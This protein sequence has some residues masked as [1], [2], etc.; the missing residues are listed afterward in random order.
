MPTSSTPL[1]TQHLTP[2]PGGAA[3]QPTLLVVDDTPASLGVVCEALRGTGAKILIADT[4]RAARAILSRIIPELILLDVVM[5][6]EDGFSF[7]E[8]LKTDPRWKQIPVLFLTSIDEPEQRLK[9]FAGGAV[10]YVTKPVQIPELLA[11]VQVQL[12]LQASKRILEKK[13][14]ELESAIAL[15]IDAEEQLAS[16]LDRAI[17]LINQSGEP[18]F[19]TRLAHGL[20][21]KYLQGNYASLASAPDRIEGVAGTLCVRHFTDG[22]RKDLQLLSL[23]EEHA[24]PGPLAL[25]SLG[26]TPRQ[27]EVAY[28]VGQGKSN[29]EVA[30][31][32]GTSPRTIDKHMEGI[33]SRLGLEN[34]SALIVECG[35][36]FTR[37]AR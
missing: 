26:L 7:C 28:W 30:I 16:S 9:A 34:R 36:I 33:L 20:V 31:I 23:E 21:T 29:P 11:R 22:P 6:V 32:L 5:P 24:Q 12:D 25:L 13:N 1:K 37:D 17:I 18:L 14:L 35:R 27:A 2:S 19:S 15:R 4:A 3:W 10:D 8:T